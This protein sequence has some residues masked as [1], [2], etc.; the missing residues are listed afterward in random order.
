MENIISIVKSA[1]EAQAITHG[2]IFH[3]DEVLATVILSKLK[4]DLTVCRTFKVPEGI[5]K[6]V[7]IYD[8]GGGEYDHHQKGGNGSR[9]NG[10][11]YSSAGLLWRKFGLEIVR[12][13]PNPELVWKIID[14]DL[15]EGVDAIDNGKMPKADYPAQALTFSQII[16]GFNP[17]WNS[18]ESPDSAFLKAV[19]FARVVFDNLLAKAISHAEA[20]EI[21]EKAIDT[22]EDSIL[23]LDQFVPW[24]EY[25]L[26]SANHKAE[27]VLFVVY[28]SLRGGFN[29]QCVPDSLGGFGQRK[30][31][32]EEWKG[33]SGEALQKVTGISDATFCHNAGFIG[34]AET[35]A[36]AIALAEK[37]VKC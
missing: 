27:N 32:P 33:L 28:P 30:S 1:T 9:E 35:L 21:V 19:E 8:I 26:T 37:A 2:G 14:R 29:W 16:S 5:S 3:A 34:A 23:V 22:T 10:V 17:N 4:G 12:D 7:I 24:Q 13:T 6:D 15:I 31:V 25:L 11:P 36:G 20:Q 18:K